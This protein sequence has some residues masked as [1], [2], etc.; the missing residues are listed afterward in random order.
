MRV[1]KAGRPPGASLDAMCVLVAEK[2]V[3][4][5]ALGPIPTEWGNIPENECQGKLCLRLWCRTRTLSSPESDWKDSDQCGAV[6]CR[7]RNKL[8]MSRLATHLA[9]TRQH[10]SMIQTCY[11]LAIR[12]L[13]LY[14][15]A[16]TS[17]SLYS[18]IVKY[19][20]VWLEYLT[21]V[22]IIYKL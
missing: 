4:V 20:W 22:D 18:S 21:L 5:L 12:W 16:L 6:L 8:P 11:W 2:K 10:F 7:V 15:S 9:S 13:E 14:S 3:Q 1:V 19:L 17:T